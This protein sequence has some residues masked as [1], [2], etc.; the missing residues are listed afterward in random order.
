MKALRWSKA[1]SSM[2]TNLWKEQLYR[3][4]QRGDNTT[5]EQCKERERRKYWKKR[6]GSCRRQIRSSKNNKS[7]AKERRKRNR[8]RNMK[9]NMMKCKE[10]IQHKL[11]Q[12]RLKSQNQQE[13]RNRLRSHK[14]RNL[15]H[16][17]NQQQNRWSWRWSN[18]NMINTPTSCGK[19]PTSPHRLHQLQRQNKS[20]VS[21]GILF[22]L[23]IIQEHMCTT[24]P[25]MSHSTELYKDIERTP[26]ISMRHLRTLKNQ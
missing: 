8:N 1:T 3:Q 15:L 12:Y 6:R 24:Y 21:K 16:R 4:K 18:G 2:K 9:R 20:Q 17:I 11:R 23:W 25:L 26:R 22:S 19:K 14:N 5:G 10:H 7:Y 13:M